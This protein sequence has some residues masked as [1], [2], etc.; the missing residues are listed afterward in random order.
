MVWIKRA[1]QTRW[2]GYCG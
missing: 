2:A 1:M